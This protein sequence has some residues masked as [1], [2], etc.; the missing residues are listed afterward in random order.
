MF[1]EASK[2]FNLAQVMLQLKQASHNA[3]W[4]FGMCSWRK[5]FEQSIST[6]HFFRNWVFSSSSDSL[7][8][9]VA[10]KQC[11]LPFLGFQT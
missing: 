2:P 10:Q 7:T 9:F 5:L 4:M 6:L 8:G 1:S 11:P 3:V